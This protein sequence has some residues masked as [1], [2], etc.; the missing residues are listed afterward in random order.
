MIYNYLVGF[1]WYDKEYRG[2]GN[3]GFNTKFKITNEKIPSIEK[4][5]KKI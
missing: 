2:T 1:S 5:L 3:S 4:A